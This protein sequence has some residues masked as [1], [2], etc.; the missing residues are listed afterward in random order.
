LP[1]VQSG[2]HP[3]DVSLAFA[4]ILLEDQDTIVHFIFQKQRE[5]IRSAKT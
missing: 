3:Y 1:G 5:E 4:D 2:D